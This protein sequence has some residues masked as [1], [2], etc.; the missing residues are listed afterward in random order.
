[1]HPYAELHVHLEGT[2]EPEMIFALAKRNKVTLPYADPVQLRASYRYSRLQ[3]FLDV[4]YANQQV[5][6]TEA[7][8]ADATTAYLDRAATTHVVHAEISVDL[9]SHLG[10]GVPAEVVLR[11]V[12]EVLANSTTTH[13]I[14]TG[15]IV[16]FLRHLPVED[17][18]QAYQKAI[19]TG[20]P[21][22]AVGLCSS[23]VGF[24]AAPFA[25]L[26]ARARADGLHTVAHA[27]EE[28]DASSIWE[29]LRL[30]KVGRID[31]GVK[32][33]ADPRLVD[34]LATYEIPVTQCPL[35]NVALQVVPNLGV[36]PLPHLLRAGVIV[37][38]N[39]DDP[40][41][42][43]GYLDANLAAATQA[44][45]LTEHDLG[46]LSENSIHSS[47]LSEAEKRRLLLVS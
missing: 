45:N 43:G 24:P 33:I 47:F 36:H 14:S 17:A 4:Y 29:V 37:S 18:E 40:A 1:M 3:D 41:Y 9:Q 26:F 13:G 16:S 30:L 23:E 31:H 12:G 25:P 44:W 39:S 34:Y 38:V 10:R 28:G 42:F 21:L 19:A 5:L 20:V 27:G 8:F 7:D 35:S 2:L 46:L 6:R 11:G 22:T 32:A 15:L